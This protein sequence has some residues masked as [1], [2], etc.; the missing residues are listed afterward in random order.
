MAE[1]KSA[2]GKP[3]KKANKASG[4][5]NKSKVNAKAR[6]PAAKKAKAQKRSTSTTGLDKSIEE[7]RSHL[8][9]NV[10]LSRERLQEVVDDAVKRGRMTRGDAEKMLSE[11]IKRGRRQTDSLLKELERLVRLARK[12]VQGRGQPVRRQATQAARRAAKK[13]G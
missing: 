6:K 7:F 1:K 10:N 12:E 3:S 11:L 13:L 5:S 2:S 8:E 4:R 9:R